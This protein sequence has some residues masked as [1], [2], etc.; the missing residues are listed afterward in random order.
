MNGRTAKVLRRYAELATR[1]QPR[2]LYHKRRWEGRVGGTPF[3]TPLVLDSVS[4][5][6]FYQRLKRKTPL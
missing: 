1:G 2:V 5:R 4:T 3:Q 6:G